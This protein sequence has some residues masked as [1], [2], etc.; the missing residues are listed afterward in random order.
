MLLAAILA[1]WW[2]PV[3]SSEALDL[4]H[5]AICEVM[6]QRTAE[7]IKIASKVG[8]FLSL[9]HLLLPWRPLGHYGASS[10]PMVVSSG[11]RGSPGHA[12]VGDVSVLLWRIRKAFKMG[13]NGGAF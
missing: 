13:H 5:R 4:L 1:Q 7:S 8:P 12:A 10:C 3:A 9:F 11:F 2:R 6:Y